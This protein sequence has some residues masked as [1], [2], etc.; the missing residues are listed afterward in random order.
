MFA[1]VAQYNIYLL[2]GLVELIQFKRLL[3]HSNTIGIILRAI[4]TGYLTAEIMYL[5]HICRRGTAVLCPY[6][7]VYLPENSCK[8]NPP[9]LLSAEY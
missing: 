3:K 7:V 4:A 2:N 8:Q 9:D 6:R 5:N 1:K